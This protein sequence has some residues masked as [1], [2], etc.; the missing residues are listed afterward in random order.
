MPLV[1]LGESYYQGRVE[2]GPNYTNEQVRHWGFGVETKPFHTNIVTVCTGQKPSGMIDKEKF[3]QSVAHYCFVQQVVGTRRDSPPTSE[4]WENSRGGFLDMLFE[5]QPACVLVVGKRL[6]EHIPSETYGVPL[7]SNGVNMPTGT[8]S[9]V[10]M[11]AI[12]HT[13]QGFSATAWRPVVQQLFATAKT[14][15][16]SDRQRDASTNR[17]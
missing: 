12:H 15:Y 1:I 17:E 2:I 7:T 10:M 11:G 16:E 14:K 8:C 9:G 4:M 6:W 3:W 5:L 13:S